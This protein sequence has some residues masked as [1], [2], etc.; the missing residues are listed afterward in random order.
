MVRKRSTLWPLISPIV[1]QARGE[2]GGKAWS[3]RTSTVPVAG[4]EGAR[5]LSDRSRA[6]CAP[7]PLPAGGALPQ[8]TIGRAPSSR[9]RVPGRDRQAAPQGRQAP[10]RE[11]RSAPASGQVM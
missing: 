2:T 3:V 5:I 10:L 6:V 8:Q 4:G 9:L 1:Q 11:R 7:T